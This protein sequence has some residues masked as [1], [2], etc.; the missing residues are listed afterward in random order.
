MTRLFK[1]QFNGTEDA[2]QFIGVY[3][4]QH[5]DEYISLN[6]FVEC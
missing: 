3:V 5:P 1:R 4:D 2:K 6:E